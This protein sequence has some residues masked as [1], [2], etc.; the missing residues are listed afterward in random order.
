M[1][2]E[3]TARKYCAFIS[4]RHKELDKAVAKKLH[5]MIERYTVP[6]ELREKWG[7]KKLG[8]VFRD[9]EELPVSSNLTDSICTAL[10]NTD[11]LIVVC[12]PDTPESIW[13][14]RE[15]SYFLDHHDR[16]HVIAVLVDGTPDTSF[17]KLITTVYDENG[18][19]TGKVEPLA[20]NLTGV[21]NKFRKSRMHKEAVRLYAAIMGVPF[22]SLWQREKRHNLHCIM[23]LVSVIAIVA[24][25]YCISI[26]MKNVKIE[27]QNEQI[28]NQYQEI[29]TQNKTIEDQNK[30]ISE[31]NKEIS[32]QNK[33]ITAQYEDIKQ[34]NKELRIKEAEALLGEGELLYEKGETQNALE[35]AIKAIST[36]E[37][38]DAFADEAQYLLTRS[39]GTMHYDNG[40][41]TVNV[42][43]TDDSIEELLLSE[44]NSRLY[45]RDAR[46][47]V[48]CY[49]TED[50]SLI[51]RGATNTIHGY[52]AA[53]KQ[54]MIE[55]SDKG[56][57]L[58]LGEK[59]VTALSLDDGSCVW[60]KSLGSIM[61]A[62][63]HVLSQDKTKLAVI[64]GS[65]ME[66]YVMKGD[67]ILLIDTADGNIIKE[68]DVGDIFE[69]NMLQAS[70]RQCGIFSEDGKKL[71][72]MVYYSFGMLSTDA[73]CLFSVDFET[74]EIKILRLNKMENAVNERTLSFVIGME[75]GDD[76]LL[77]I[78]HYDNLKKAVVAEELDEEGNVQVAYE[79][80][81][82]LPA[83]DFY[84]EYK[85]TFAR[86]DDR[87]IFS[88]ESLVAVYSLSEQRFLRLNT[89]LGVRI[90]DLS[91]INRKKNTYAYMTEDGF[92]TIYYGDRAYT[93]APFTDRNLIRHMAISKDYAENRT[94]KAGLTIKDT[95]ILAEVC[96]NNPG[97]VYILKPDKDK[98]FLAVGWYE[99][100]DDGSVTANERIKYAGD[101]ILAYW[102]AAENDNVELKFIDTKTESVT[103]EYIIAPPEGSILSA[104]SMMNDALIWPDKKHFTFG[105]GS[106]RLYI[107]DM[108]NGTMEDVFAGKRLVDSACAIS[109]SGEI[110]NLAICE[111][112]GYNVLDPKYDIYW[113]TGTGEIE[114]AEIPD[115][116]SPCI[117]NGYLR[118][119]K[120]CIGESGMMMVSLSADQ[121]QITSYLLIDPA[122][123]HTVTLE[124][125]CP[126]PVG[127]KMIISGKTEK[128]VMI[129]GNDSMLRIFD[130][131][132]GDLY[133]EFAAP[134][135]Y[136]DISSVSFLNNDTKLA[137]WTRSSILYIYDIE[138]KEQV[139]GGRFNYDKSSANSDVKVDIFEDDTRNRVFFVTSQGAVMLL[140]TDTWKKQ[141]DFNGF[142]AYCPENEELYRLKNEYMSFDEE[143]NEVIKIKVNTLQ[144][145]LQSL[146]R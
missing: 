55:I 8:R 126:G 98:D 129:L 121:S 84:K 127:E 33:E 116:L 128:K 107:Y 5:T 48:N 9:E 69:G 12:T 67:S 86:N 26:Y 123:G 49:S 54:R 135:G 17:P 75:Y 142:S 56:I 50:C 117:K 40:F 32:E 103:A 140:S 82:T 36:Q 64:S 4:Y 100:P 46:G 94:G 60:S 99:A 131:R 141:A 27:E 14:E 3:I 58:C 81:I 111:A 93:K 143:T 134:T 125:K 38:L 101:G 29:L 77:T 39:L 144:E 118:S 15:I 120:I 85:S 28:T 57:M 102:K 122:D 113:K 104:S 2:S 53:D 18:N 41:R 31:Q 79:I 97:A 11:Y 132:T 70:G 52:F 24:L 78:I 30:E 34:K 73:S 145:Y 71:T 90:L 92:Q 89:D 19:E 65:Y 16:S 91:C 44:D 10:D 138:T 76:G 20:A 22:D 6:G 105:M 66:N 119:S 47:Y 37:G 115:G 42:L 1:Q 136:N 87:I 51:W 68:L 110:Y 61:F 72:C 7:G 43:E 21:D 106:S 62:D 95:S 59:E 108:E 114:Q 130:G 146:D 96:E 88:C 25:G 80:A 137:I 45:V 133:R 83:R 124:E 139:F 13:V 63:L 23:D 112:E 109:K 74:D 35:C